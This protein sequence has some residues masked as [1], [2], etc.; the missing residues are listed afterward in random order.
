[1]KKLALALL[2]GLSLS[3]SA[4]TITTYSTR[5]AFNAATSGDTTTDFSGIAGPSG[6]AY[7]GNSFTIGD[8][9]FNDSS[10]NLIGYRGGFVD[11]PFTSNYLNNNGGSFVAIN[12]AHPVY[13]FAF[14]FGNLADWSRSGGAFIDPYESFYFAGLDQGFKMPAGFLDKSTPGGGAPIS[15]VGYTSDTPFSRIQISNTYESLAFNNFTYSS[16]A[17]GPSG[18]TVPEP[19]T[20]ALLGLG[21]L[22][23]GAA[24]TLKRKPV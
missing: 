12:F 21:I 15:F 3:A 20:A 22:A 9:T 10:A 4:T 16:Q 8:V 17:A 2:T 23:I 1:M 6:Y 7:H 19:T 13:G 14:D 18:G 11:D 24:A 5:A